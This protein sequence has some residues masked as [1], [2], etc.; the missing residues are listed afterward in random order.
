MRFHKTQN[1][2]IFRFH[3]ISL[4]MFAISFSTLSLYYISTLACPYAHILASC[5][6]FP[7]PAF[8]MHL[9]STTSDTA[10][11]T[12]SYQGLS[13]PSTRRSENAESWIG[14]L[15]FWLFWSVTIWFLKMVVEAAIRVD[16]KLKFN[17]TLV[18]LN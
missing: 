16:T 13:I 12:P 14:S 18:S 4:T 8:S 9:H 2:F 3:N 17:N 10:A 5:R 1:Y 7:E 11:I 15:C 6:L